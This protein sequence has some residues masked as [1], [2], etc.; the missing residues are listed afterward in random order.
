MRAPGGIGGIRRPIGRAHH[1]R[2]GRPPPESSCPPGP[3]CRQ[4]GGMPRLLAVG[5]IHGCS[6]A[7]DLLLADV[8]PHADDTVVTLGDYVDRG[9]DAKGVLDRL[10]DLH[11]TGRLIPLR[12][13]HEQ[14]L[15]AARTSRDERSFWLA[16]GGEETLLSYGRSGRPAALA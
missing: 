11:H 1:R 13:N 9:P 5:D 10:I 7:L 6:R 14:M 8:N 15:V 3:R 4:S 12:G 2:P 16:C